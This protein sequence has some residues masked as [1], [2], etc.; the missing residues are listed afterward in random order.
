MVV[1]LISFFIVGVIVANSGNQT[2]VHN[3]THIHNYINHNYSYY[4]DTGISDL[5]FINEMIKR[6]ADSHEYSDDYVCDNFSKD[7]ELLGKMT[8]IKD[9]N[10]ITGSKECDSNSIQHAWNRLY[11]DLSPQ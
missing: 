5:E 3:H 11:I 1:A 4:D 6:F 7:M 2:I 10:Y 9:L 8:G